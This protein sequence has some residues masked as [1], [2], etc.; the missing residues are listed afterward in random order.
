MPAPTTP[1]VAVQPTAH[2]ISS[3]SGGVP[4]YIR[5]TYHTQQACPRRRQAVQSARGQARAAALEVARDRGSPM[6]G[7]SPAVSPAASTAAAPPAV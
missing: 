4:D 2:S 5:Q 3:G 1:E 7:N 6:R